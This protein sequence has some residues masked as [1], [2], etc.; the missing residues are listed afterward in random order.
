MIERIVQNIDRVTNRLGEVSLWLVIAMVI[1]Q[2]LVVLLSKV[3]GISFTPLDESVWY[4]NGLI[5]MLGAAYTLLHNRHVRVD[6]IYHDAGN[7]YKAWVDLFGSLVFILPVAFM[8]FGL[9]WGF[10]LDSWYNFAT[11]EWLLERAEG[12]AAS[13]PLISPFKTII[14]LYAIT[15][16]LSALSL[17]GKAILYLSGQWADYNPAMAAKGRGEA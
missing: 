15:I 16:A 17:A 6:L 2:F 5:F 4:L 10:V 14:W 3:Y 7:R 8:T 9:S 11:S 12:T 13:L 1:C